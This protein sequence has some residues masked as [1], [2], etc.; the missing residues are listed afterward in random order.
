MKP[1]RKSAYRNLVL[2]AASLIAA[3]MITAPMA[4]A[5][6]QKQPRTSAQTQTNPVDVNAA[7]AKTLETLPGIGATLANKI[8]AGR[9]YHSLADLGKVKGLGPSKLDA[10]KN[11]ISF[12]PAT[13]AAAA[14]K[15]AK[16]AAQSEA[17]SAN[18]VSSSGK[19]TDARTPSTP[20][21][22]AAGKLAPGQMINI[23]KATAEE[24]DA[25]P[26]IGP[27][28]AGA[29]IDYRTQHGDF[30]TIEDIE[31]V[32]GIKA[33]EFSKIKDHIKVAN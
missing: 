31:N 8:I 7:D 26:G 5:Q 11:D 32:K 6:A 3:G 12:G 20:T 10:I 2:L 21:G 14:M 9:P 33:G 15:R 30:K 25:L 16:A 13:S 17:T 22:R 27:T 19:E 24:L 28:K 1:I 23:N 18:N 29:I 4:R